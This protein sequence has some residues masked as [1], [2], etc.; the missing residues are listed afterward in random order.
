MDRA[1]EDSEPDKRL[2]LRGFCLVTGALAAA[3]AVLGFFPGYESYSGD[4]HPEVAPV[5][6]APFGLALMMAIVV[7]I[8]VHVW[9]RP[10]LANALL[11]SMIS[12]GTSVFLLALT[13][14]PFESDHFLA[15]RAAAIANQLVLALVVVQIVALPVAC[16]LFAWVTRARRP[17]RIARARVH[18]IAR[19]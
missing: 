6:N 8:A 11:G 12:V 1:T 4:G 18:R 17:D 13:A 15:L 5:A 14:P 2:M 7:A 16:G 19:R 3:L 9:R 10:L